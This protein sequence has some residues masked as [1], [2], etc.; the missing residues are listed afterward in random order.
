MTYT[1]IKDAINNWR[2]HWDAGR[3]KHDLGP[4]DDNA[5][6]EYVNSLT[7]AEVLW[8]LEVFDET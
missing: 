6:N 5:W 4:T 3:R 2:Y 8:N 1:P 7:M